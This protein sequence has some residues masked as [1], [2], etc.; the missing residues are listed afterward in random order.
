MFN[1]IDFKIIIYALIFFSFIMF[2]FTIYKSKTARAIIYFVFFILI[3]M[4][5]ANYKK[6]VRLPIEI[7]FITLGVVFITYSFGLKIGLTFA[8]IG[9]ILTFIVGFNISPFSFPMLIGYILMAFTTFFFNYFN[10]NLSISYIGLIA[11]FVNY[12]FVFLFY[13]FVFDYDPIKN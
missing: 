6:F 3:N 2:I 9:G 5:L 4:I 10:F 1:K 13:H 8:I 7:E 11:S 12:I